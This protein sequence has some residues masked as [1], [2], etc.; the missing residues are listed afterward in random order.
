MINQSS[1]NRILVGLSWTL[2]AAFIDLSFSLFPAPADSATFGSLAAPMALDLAIFSAVSI[3]AMALASAVTFR[4][5]SHAIPL[6]LGIASFIAAVLILGSPFNRLASYFDCQ[7]ERLLCRPNVVRFVVPALI[8]GACVTLFAGALRAS[9]AGPRHRL[10]GMGALVAIPLLAAVCAGAIWW[11]TFVGVPATATEIA[12]GLVAVFVA[13]GAVALVALA[14][15]RAERSVSALTLVC[16]VVI[17]GV[18]ARG[19]P[20]A[21]ELTAGERRGAAVLR[22]STDRP[23]LILLITVDALRADALSCYGDPTRETPNIDRMASEGVLFERAFSPASWTPYAVPSMMTGLD[24]VVLRSGPQTGLPG[25][26]R[27]VADRLSDAGYFTA[28]IVTN[29]LLGA[30]SGLSR[31]FDDYRLIVPERRLVTVL[32]GAVGPRWFRRVSGNRRS[33]MKTD[34]ST[35]TAA[36]IEV[37]RSHR[38]VDVFLWLHYFDPHAPYERHPPME[39]SFESFDGTQRVT[40]AQDRETVRRLYQGEV[41]RAD[42]AIGGLLDGIRREGLFD[43]ALILLTADHGEEH[44]EHGRLFHGINLYDET[45]RVP[46]IVKTPASRQRG[47]SSIPVST[48]SLPASILEAAHVSFDA[49]AFQEPAIEISRG[50]AGDGEFRIVVTT[51]DPTPP[52]EPKAAVVFGGFKYIRSLVSN[53]DELYDLLSD[54]GERTSLA[55]LQPGRVS[56]GRRLLDERMAAGRALRERLHLV[57]VP[58]RSDAETRDRLKTLGYIH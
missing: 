19:F 54:P 16:V 14:A 20:S 52:D 2:S 39:A 18:L 24:P 40:T 50:S 5:R 10:F 44:W 57:A 23:R 4:H 12:W 51:S 33:A 46:L 15:A 31:G 37:V 36:A 29:E 17:A 41:H 3:G 9:M 49:A 35:V 26:V 8:G 13:L 21:I 42:A 43:S 45:V 48:E 53:R 6:G 11:V 30:G 25:G 1:R 28:A 7:P 22:S 38:D 27:T 47:R 32:N 56:D 34:G 58:R 55:T